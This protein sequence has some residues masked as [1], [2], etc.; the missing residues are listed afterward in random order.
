MS[1][2]NN[3]WKFFYQKGDNQKPA[4]QKDFINGLQDEKH[5]KYILLEGM[6]QF[7][8]S[9]LSRSLTKTQM[10]NIFDL[11]KNKNDE[12]DLISRQ[13]RLTYIAGKSDKW[14]VKEF[15]KLLIDIY[16]ENEETAKTFIESALAY[17]KFHARN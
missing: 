3:V 12:N 11:I 13:I 15:I 1:Q 17:H 5:R 2:E 10:R 8:K 14:E 4:N 16:N 6:E 7:V 9:K